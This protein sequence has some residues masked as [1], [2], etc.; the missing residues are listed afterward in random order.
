MLPRNYILSPDNP[1]SGV[2]GH[3]G[4]ATRGTTQQTFQYDGL[5]R[6]TQAV[7]TT[8]LDGITPLVATV[9]VYFDSLNRVVE[10]DQ[11]HDL[12]GGAKN[13]YATYNEF[14]SLP[15]IRFTYPN[16]REVGYNYD[17]LY[18][19]IKI[20]DDPDDTPADIADWSFFGPGRVA[21][22][23]L[24]SG[25]ICTHMNNAR[26][27]S[28]VQSSVSN[29]VWGD[30]SSD[31]LGYDG[32][33]RMIT[34][35]YLDATAPDTGYTSTASLVGF[36]TAYDHGSNKRYERH[37]HAESRSHLYPGL[38]SL[39]RLLQY[40]R[41]TLQEAGN[42]D[43][44]V[45]TAISLSGTDSD[46]TYD[47][48][49]LGNWNR[50][51]YTSA[52]APQ[53]VSETRAHNLVNQ[54]TRFATTDVAYDHGDNGATAREGNGNIVDDG[55]RLYLYDAFNRL[56]MVL[57]KSGPTL[58]VTYSY[59]AMG[60]RIRK[61]IE[62]LGGNLGGLTG[63]IPAGT[64]DYLYT[65][66][67]CVEERDDADDVD[68]HYVWGAYVD[69]LI[70]QKDIVAPTGTYYPLSDLLYR[71]MALTDHLKAIQ[72]VYDTDAY[73]NTLI[74]DADGT[75]N[76]WFTDD[77]VAAND[78]ICPF[79]FTGRRYDPETQ[80][81]FYRARYYHPQLGRFISR[82]PDGYS[83]GANLYQYVEGRAVHL[84]DPLG[85]EA[86]DPYARAGWHYGQMERAAKE[87]RWR[88]RQ[89]VKQGDKDLEWWATIWLDNWKDYHEWLDKGHRGGDGKYISDY[90]QLRITEDECCGK[91]ATYPILDLD[92]RKE[93]Q[94]EAM[95][96][97]RVRILAEGTRFARPFAI[98]RTVDAV[99]A[100]VGI[101]AGVLLLAPPFTAIGVG[102]LMA[103]GA[104][105]VQGVMNAREALDR[106]VASEEAFTRY[107]DCDHIIH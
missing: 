10:E 69:E 94:K 16:G 21:E 58:L 15:P 44:T 104:V 72:E 106:I 47:L 23:A 40:Q 73:G 51:T 50:T 53:A 22:L 64:T 43:V 71:T 96:I 25:L 52:G 55:S 91:G 95:R 105:V 90:R 60:R 20:E 34:K 30:R 26:T 93:H 35:R 102:T 28:A 18:R 92:V 29:P 67:Q 56:M 33:G 87:V 86:I 46:R 13:R 82:D 36:T 1:A 98:M 81:Y 68:R 84:A 32:A 38:D 49:G 2:A 107:C 85:L 76:T 61:V 78:P 101:V 5:S 8:K 100:A 48:D 62:D 7:D 83:D 79:I 39:D 24:V 41:G 65:D 70:Q 99:G 3:D 45:A 89:G 12:D 4:D 66:V 88:L 17:E 59:D 9:D 75:D 80:I 14:T 74:Y 54:V 57:D 77:D 103:S 37:L 27:N 63:D 19:R 6:K 97:C 11:M 42:G 31:R